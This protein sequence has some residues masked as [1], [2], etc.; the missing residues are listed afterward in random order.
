MVV[1]KVQELV[2]VEAVVAVTVVVVIVIREHDRDTF[3]YLKL[4]HSVVTLAP[5]TNIYNPPSS[6]PL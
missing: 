3:S 6:L 4:S 2:V 1:T 5:F